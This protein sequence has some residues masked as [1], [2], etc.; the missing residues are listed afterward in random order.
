MVVSLCAFHVRA[1]SASPV[2]EGVAVKPTGADGT[3]SGVADAS[4]DSSPSPVALTARSLN[5]Y[6]VPFVSPV[7]VNDVVDAPLFDISV[8]LP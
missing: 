3:G 5:L 4:A 7:A 6:S 2:V 1:T 8:Q